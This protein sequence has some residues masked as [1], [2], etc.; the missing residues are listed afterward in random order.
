MSNEHGRKHVHLS[1]NRA[2]ILECCR[3]GLPTGTARCMWHSLTRIHSPQIP[4]SIPLLRTGVGKM[5]SCITDGDIY[6][7]ILLNYLG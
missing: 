5:R 2:A 7:K 4:F 3:L 6:L 1:H